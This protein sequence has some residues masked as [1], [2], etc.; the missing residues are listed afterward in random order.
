M[1]FRK[2]KQNKKQT[3]TF[4]LFLN[5]MTLIILK[6]LL[7]LRCLFPSTAVLEIKQ[8]SILSFLFCPDLIDSLGITAA[9][10]IN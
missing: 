8:F 1:C 6:K 9:N 10:L 5:V 3:H 4:I 2:I 7:Q